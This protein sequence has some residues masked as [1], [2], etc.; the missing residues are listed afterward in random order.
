M[1]VLHDGHQIREASAE[2]VKRDDAQHV[3]GTE[4]LKRCV[5]TGASPLRTRYPLVAKDG[6]HAHFGARPS[7]AGRSATSY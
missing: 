5:Q 2:P 6:H 7:A 4:F 1:Q 3:A